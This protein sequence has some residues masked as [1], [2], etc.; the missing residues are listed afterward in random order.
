MLRWGCVFSWFWKYRVWPLL[1]SIVTSLCVGR[2]R[3]VQRKSHCG[4]ALCA[5]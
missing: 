1:N 5:L 4:S 2:Q 3:P